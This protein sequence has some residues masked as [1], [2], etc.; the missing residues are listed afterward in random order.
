LTRSDL[1]LSKILGSKT[2]YS[3]RS[4]GGGQFV[5]VHPSAEA[6]T[7]RETIYITQEPPRLSTTARPQAKIQRTKRSERLAINADSVA[8]TLPRSFQSKA[9]RPSIRMVPGAANQFVKTQQLRSSASLNKLTP[10][11][12]PNERFSVSPMAKKSPTLKS[13]SIPERRKSPIRSPPQIT[14]PKAP[15]LHTEL[16]SYRHKLADEINSPKSVTD[17]VCSPI[18]SEGDSS[19]GTRTPYSGTASVE[20]NKNARSQRFSDHIQEFDEPRAGFER[21][22]QDGKTSGRQL[23][24]APHSSP[25]DSPAR[26]SSETLSTLEDS[27][28][29]IV[30]EGE[31]AVRTS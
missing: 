7:S 5:V 18:A 6:S 11:S 30:T 14:V 20:F 31:Q 19:R 1:H 12:S 23:P 4:I 10:N 25:S 27:D 29:L 24:Q 15:V 22:Q 2:K 28:I 26:K 16:R 8:K 21:H 13:P 3:L 17:E 9:P